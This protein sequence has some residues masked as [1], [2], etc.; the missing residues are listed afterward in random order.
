[1]AQSSTSTDG[2]SLTIENQDKQQLSTKKGD[3]EKK[4]NPVV[5][6]CSRFAAR[7]WSGNKSQQKTETHNV[8]TYVKPS[9]LNSSIYYCQ[10]DSKDDTFKRFCSIFL[11]Q[12][13]VKEYK[14]GQTTD[15]RLFLVLNLPIENRQN[16]EEILSDFIAQVCAKY[17]I[18]GNTEIS[19]V[20]IS[21]DGNCSW[22]PPCLMDKTIFEKLKN[23][24]ER[25][26]ASYVNIIY[27]DAFHF[28]D[29]DINELA[30]ETLKAL[31][32]MM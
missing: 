28:I 25:N 5:S 14:A 17:Q 11:P 10:K 16:R 23:A 2:K 21:F 6:A 24:T 32:Y 29:C 19:I 9:M 3:G 30:A 22:N 4:T 31:S 15:C 12:L 27:T 7:L 1:M 26:F 20:Q 8:G 18:K 13:E